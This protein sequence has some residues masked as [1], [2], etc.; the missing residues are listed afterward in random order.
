MNSQLPSKR[1]RANVNQNQTLELSIVLSIGH[2]RRISQVGLTAALGELGA[3]SSATLYAQLGDSENFALCFLVN[4]DR[5]LFT[6][7]GTRTNTRHDVRN[8]EAKFSVKPRPRNGAPRRAARRSYRATEL[9]SQP[10]LEFPIL[11]IIEVFEQS[12]SAGVFPL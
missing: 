10:I 1:S 5:H 11:R 8:T 7:P 3:R 9:C 4:S 12:L 6:W 2:K